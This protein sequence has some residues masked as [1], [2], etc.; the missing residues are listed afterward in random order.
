MF[1]PG[2]SGTD[3]LHPA[4]KPDIFK[5]KRLTFPQGSC[6]EILRMGDYRSFCLLTGVMHELLHPKEPLEMINKSPRRVGS[7]ADSCCI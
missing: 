2:D 5:A 1:V 4:T 3:L 6:L 7:T